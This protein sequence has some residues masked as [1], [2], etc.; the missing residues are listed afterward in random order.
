MAQ[1]NKK[2][3]I[4][5]ENRVFNITFQRRFGISEKNADQLHSSQFSCTIYTLTKENLSFKPAK[6]Y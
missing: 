6:A 5:S 2:I 4:K 3:I 1:I